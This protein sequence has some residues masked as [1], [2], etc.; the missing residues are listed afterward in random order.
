MSANIPEDKIKETL[1]KPFKGTNIPILEYIKNEQ[2]GFEES[3]RVWANKGFL[4]K[5]AKA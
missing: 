3:R 2:Y 4:G 1:S 5:K